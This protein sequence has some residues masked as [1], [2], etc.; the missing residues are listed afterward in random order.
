[1]FIDYDILHSLKLRD[2]PYIWGATNELILPQYRQ[3]LVRLFPNEGFISCEA[4]RE[5]K[6]YSM[7]CKSV[8]TDITDVHISENSLWQQF[9]EEIVSKQYIDALSL[10]NG[11][12]LHN[13]KIELNLWKYCYGNWLSP[14]TD[15]ED[16]VF[17][18]LL[19]FNAAW[20]KLGGGALRILN[21]NN[22]DDY[23]Q[24]IYP[25]P[26]HS[27]FLKRSSNSWHSVSLQ[28]CNNERNV[29]QIVFKEP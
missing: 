22:E 21:S 13:K 10:L 15:K 7:L 20:P 24:Q 8:S 14:H 17:T 3:G 5:D 16:K 11:Y 28:T 1:M 26:C 12:S 6:S 23:H 25:G 27:V 29:L 18:Q 9:I 19:Y 4:N 2:S